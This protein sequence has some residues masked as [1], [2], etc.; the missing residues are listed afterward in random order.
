MNDT[1]GSPFSVRPD[2][3]AVGVRLTPK[4]GR[5]R[6]GPAVAGRRPGEAGALKVAVTTVPENGKANARLID[7]LAKAW[8]LPKS[9]IALQ[10]GATARDK[11]LLVAGDPAAVMAHLTRWLETRHA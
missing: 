1:T 3:V 6:I 7:L 11:T 10:A 4:A 2:G 8:R 5:D 9:A